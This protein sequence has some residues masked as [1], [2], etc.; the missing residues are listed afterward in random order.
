EVGCD[1]IDLVRRETSRFV[2]WHSPIDVI[3]NG[4]RIGP[5]AS[6]RLHRL[7]WV[8]RAFA[9]DQGIVG[10]F[11]AGLAVATGATGRVNLGAFGRAPTTR[12]K[13]LAIRTNGEVP[14]FDL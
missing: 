8:L 7:F 6:D 3:P 5:V 2:I 10:T 13:F 9:A 12:R 11:L 1:R 14:G 4:R